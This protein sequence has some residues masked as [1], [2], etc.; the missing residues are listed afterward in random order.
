[1]GLNTCDPTTYFTP[2][3]INEPEV[4][5]RVNRGVNLALMICNCRGG[6]PEFLQGTQND[7]FPAHQR[8]QPSTGG[9]GQ[10]LAP[11]SDKHLAAMWGS[12]KSFAAVQRTHCLIEDLGSTDLEAVNKLYPSSWQIFSH[13]RRP[14]LLQYLD[15][16]CECEFGRVLPTKAPG[17]TRGR[18]SG[19]SLRSISPW[20]R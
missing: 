14:A 17:I 4:P 8:Q 12:M 19:G 10:L 5:T 13:S 15:I 18:F 3:R 9:S 11:R 7:L 6:G 16:L 1:M 2:Q 20:R